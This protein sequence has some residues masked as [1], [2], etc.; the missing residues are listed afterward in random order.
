MEGQTRSFVNQH[1]A[2]DVCKQTAGLQGEEDIRGNDGKIREYYSLSSSTE[3]VSVHSYGCKIN[4]VKRGEVA[5]TD[6]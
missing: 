5:G 6:L 1:V 2:V 3:P 4:H